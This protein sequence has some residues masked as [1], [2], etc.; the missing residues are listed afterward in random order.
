MGVN[1]WALPPRRGIANARRAVRGLVGPMPPILHP[2]GG[3]M[4][5]RGPS[6][7]P[8]LAILIAFRVLILAL[9]LVLIL[10]LI[11]PLIALLLLLRLVGRFR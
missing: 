3:A 6:E 1:C 10:G 11:R 2:F 7:A 8:P 4:C 9:A 5:G